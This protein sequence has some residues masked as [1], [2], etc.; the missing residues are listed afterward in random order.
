MNI[1]L[2]SDVESRI[3][4]KIEREG[5]SSPEQVIEHAMTALEVRD[6]LEKADSDRLRKLIQVGLD[7]ADR[8]ESTPLDVNEMLAKAHAEYEQRSSRG[9]GKAG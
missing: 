4:R 7:Q 2:Q 5:Y 3:R 9:H 6:E 8:G 1:N